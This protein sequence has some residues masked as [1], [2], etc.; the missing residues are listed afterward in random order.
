MSILFYCSGIQGLECPAEVDLCY[1]MFPDFTTQHVV[2]SQKQTV[3]SRGKSPDL[4]G[5]PVVG[6]I[7]ALTSQPFLIATILFLIFQLELLSISR[8]AMIW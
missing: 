2:Y 1:C 7:L 8:S 6:S 4:F 3:E 5:L